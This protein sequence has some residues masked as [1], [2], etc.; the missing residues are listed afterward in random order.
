MIVI[1]MVAIAVL[2][3]VVIVALALRR[4]TFAEGRTEAR[5][6]QPGPNTVAY[7]V[8][9]G[10]D[11]A[12]LVAALAHEGYAAVADPEH[13]VEMLHVE[14]PHPGDRDHVRSIL[15]HLDR[16]GLAAAVLHVD[17]VRFEDER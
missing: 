11:A 6:R 5:L 17:Q 2:V 15:E 1:P 14:C 10:Q 7:V 4:A 3:I 9:N 12:V 16:T 13:G 8:P